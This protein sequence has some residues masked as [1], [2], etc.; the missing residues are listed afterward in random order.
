MTWQKK[1]R[2]AIGVF[3]IVF[4]AIVIVALRTR[5]TV[6]QTGAIPERKD[7][8]AI[9]ENPT[10]GNFSCAKEGRIVFAI[11]FGS[12]FIYPDGRTKFGN[13]VELTSDRN[14]RKFTVTSREADIVQNGPDLKTAHFTGRGKA[15]ERGRR[16]HRRRGHLRRGGGDREDAGRGRVQARADDRHAASAPPTI[17]TARSSGCSTGAHHRLR[18]R[19]G[20]GRARGDGHRRGDGAGS[21]TTCA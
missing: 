15:H 5:K 9:V 20:A 7:P 8:K 10:G 14:G 1:A 17:A 18:G 12:Q 6:P 2:L 11:K 16:G 19:E 21:S 13:G 4:V 3:V